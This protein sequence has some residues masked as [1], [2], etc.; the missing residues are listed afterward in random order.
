MPEA[1]VI[2]AGPGGLAAAAML[3][4]A[5]IETVVIDRAPAIASSWRGHYDRLHLHT[6]RWLSHLPGYRIPRRYG[7][8]VARDDVVR[9]LESYSAHHRLDVCL[10]TEVTAIDRR[11]DDGW[12]VRISVGDFDARYVIVATGHNHTPVM[13]SWPGA[14]EF[15]GELVHASAYR[16]A[17]PYVGKSVLV[18]GSG[19]TGAEIAVD[20]VESGAREVTLAVRTPP[21]IVLREKYGVPSLALGV[22]FRHLPP[23]VFDRIA[24]AVRRMDV[25][26]LSAYGLPTPKD[27]L[28]ER[29]LRDDQ[30]PLIDA[31]F[32][33]QLKAG[34]IVVVPAV[35]GF[36][37]DH[38]LLADG[39]RRRADVVIAATGYRRGLD[40]LVGHLGV[41][42]PDGRPRVRG[43]ATDPAAPRLWFTGFT[44]PIS[45]MFRELGIDAKRIARAVVRDRAISRPGS[46]L[47]DVLRVSAPGVVR[48][49]EPIRS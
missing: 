27:G 4:R 20:L 18:V 7:R 39:S 8:W 47:V 10:N 19:N 17:T 29:V 36:E 2:G 40:R 3:Q 33:Q 25:G 32:L 43:G 5:G 6:A 21:H 31:G 9:Y 12:T 42:G 45:G 41:L 1:V 35:E 46:P 26:D 44:N 28:Y 16:N 37:G 30:I 15:P 24:A 48:G 13:P 23:K 22:L 11:A 38:V 14:E 34:R 49:R